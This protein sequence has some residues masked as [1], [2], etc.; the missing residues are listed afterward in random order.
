MWRYSGEFNKERRMEN[1]SWFATLSSCWLVIACPLRAFTVQTGTQLL[2]VTFDEPNLIWA[3]T[4]LNFFF[5]GVFF[6]D[7]LLVT[8]QRLC[9][10]CYQTSWTSGVR[11]SLTV[12]I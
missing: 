7:L 9:C 1:L 3:V 8:F 12:E 11:K 2:E 10:Q 4:L 5:L 6:V